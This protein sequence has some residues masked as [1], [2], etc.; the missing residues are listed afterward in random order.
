MAWGFDSLDQRVFSLTRIPALVSLMDQPSDSILVQEYAKIANCNLPTGMGYR[1][2]LV[3]RNRR[4]FCNRPG[5][6]RRI[7]SRRHSVGRGRANIRA[8]SNAGVDA[9]P[10]TCR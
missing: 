7:R 1:R 5:D 3:R 6:W 9:D 8:A 10:F 2:T 4:S